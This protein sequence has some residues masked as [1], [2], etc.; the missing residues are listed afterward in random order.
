MKCVFAGWR[1]MS[2]LWSRRTHLFSA[3]AVILLL[4]CMQAPVIAHAQSAGS[5]DPPVM[6][7]SGEENATTTWS[8]LVRMIHDRSEQSQALRSRLDSIVHNP[9]SPPDTRSPRATL[10]S[11][12]VI[13]AEANELWFATRDRYLARHS[14]WMSPEEEEN[15]AKV[16]ALFEKAAQTLDLSQISASNREQSVIELVLQLQEILSRIHLPELVEIPGVGAGA[17]ETGE[18]GTTRDKWI[19]PGTSLTIERQ[20]DG[21][22][23]GEYLF[24]TATV[25]RIPDDYDTLKTLPVISEMT[26]DTYRYYIYTPGTLIA[27]RWNQ[28]ILDG[29]DW[30]MRQIGRQ[31][32]W[33]WIGMILT[34]VVLLSAII[35]YLRWNARRPIPQ[36]RGRRQLRRIAHPVLLIL[37]VNL[38][39]H[40]CN[41]QLNITGA[42]LFFITTVG[43][44]IVWIAAAWLSYQVL[45]LIYI[46]TVQTT[47]SPTSFDSSLLQ[48]GFRALSFGI[49]LLV[50]GYGATQ[51]GIPIYG[52]IAGLGVGG[53]AIALA[54]QPT[55][56][57]FIGG[58]ILYA[59][60]IVRVGEYCAFDDLAGTV[61]EIGIRSTRIR[62]L[63][64]TLITVAN[65][66]LSKRKIVN[67]SKRGAFMFRHQIRLRYDTPSDTV[68]EIIAGVRDY[69]AAHDRVPESPLRV[70]LVEYGEFAILIDI[71]ANL[72]AESMD[73]FTALQE[74]LLYEIREVVETNGTGFAIPSST[75]HVVSG[76]EA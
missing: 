6:A 38:A 65:A 74:E 75:I 44:L 16:R 58:L 24:T 5:G 34:V 3:L 51:I 56:E 64:Q 33:Q 14:L 63:D 13:M 52:V 55:L 48:T 32:V 70:R 66:D 61:E 47:E 1:M 17:A 7:A 53:L 25:D 40:V 67:Y 2:A 60:G 27:P 69:L 31:T 20:A 62:A 68:K 19:L 28:L 30:L 36:G 22:R 42:L 23:R 4:T 45:Q 46:W 59:D 11:F 50:L 76:M 73:E 35:V 71:Y 43:S 18:N 54:A 39:V 29:P 15:V 49:A 72:A 12:L 41:D 10:S 57:N 37:A 8:S 21:P 9:I 26:E